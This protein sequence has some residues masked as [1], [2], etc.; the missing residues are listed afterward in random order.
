MTILLLSLEIEATPHTCLRKNAT[1]DF[2]TKAKH[3]KHLFEEAVQKTKNVLV[4]DPIIAH[5]MT[6]H[7][8]QF[9]YRIEW[10]KPLGSARKRWDGESALLGTA[11]ITDGIVRAVNDY[12]T[13]YYPDRPRLN[14]RDVTFAPVEQEIPQPIGGRYAAKPRGRVLVEIVSLGEI[15]PAPITAALIADRRQCQALTRSNARCLRAAT[16]SLIVDAGP[17]IGLCPT[18]ARM[19]KQDKDITYQTI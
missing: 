13:L 6:F 18:H 10:E 19:A 7:R 2:R 8:L 3:R 15:E 9:C 16:A 14:D 11:A 5:A 17:C 1:D 4:T 12:L